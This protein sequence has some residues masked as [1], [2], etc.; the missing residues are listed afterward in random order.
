MQFIVSKTSYSIEIEQNL[1]LNLLD[2]ESYVTDHATYKDDNKTLCEKLGQ[3]TGVND[4]EYNG[5]FGNFIYLTIDK[6]VD[7]KKTKDQISKIIED[8]L[9]WCKNL[10]KITN[11]FKNG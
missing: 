10:E 5:H 8:H 11:T 6:D 7:N 2:S 1:F 4:I 9:E 3:I